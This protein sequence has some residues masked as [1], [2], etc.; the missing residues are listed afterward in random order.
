MYI[1]TCKSH[2]ATHL[3]QVPVKKKKS[4][5]KHDT[6][7][8]LS[9]PSN[10]TVLPIPLPHWPQL[11]CEK[12]KKLELGL[13]PC[14]T[15]G[16]YGSNQLNAE[17]LANAKVVESSVRPARAVLYSFCSVLLLLF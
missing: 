16:I 10:L 8:A 13:K 17:M 11:K 1:N 14:R 15:Q 3:D 4:W 9:P 5:A 2:N 6:K 7:S 12:K